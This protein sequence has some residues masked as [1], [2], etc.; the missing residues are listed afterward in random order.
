MVKAMPHIRPEPCIAARR[1]LRGWLPNEAIGKWR[2]GVCNAGKRTMKLG[3][4]TGSAAAI[5]L[6]GSIGAR[7]ENPTAKGLHDT[8]YNA[9]DLPAHQ[10]GVLK[11]LG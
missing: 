1:S 4:L 6:I 11:L 8:V 10:Q 7:A 3:L 5:L 9:I 2:V